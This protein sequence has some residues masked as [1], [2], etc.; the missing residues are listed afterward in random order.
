MVRSF[1]LLISLALSRINA[2]KEYVASSKDDVAE[3]CC[4][5]IVTVFGGSVQDDVH[6]AVAVHHLS[7]VFDIVLQFYVHVA[8]DLLDKEVDGFFRWF[9]VDPTQIFLYWKIY[10]NL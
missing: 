4:R 3:I 10:I 6:V 7:S 2:D 1:P 9:Q 8:I 5:C